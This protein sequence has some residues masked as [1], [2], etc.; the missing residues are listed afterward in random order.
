MPQRWVEQA[1]RLIPN[2]ILV[3]IP[4]AAH[5]VNFNAADALVAEVMKFVRLD[6]CQ[7]VD[8]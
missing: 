2:G 5:A 1:V 3:T 4:A 6:S 7:R 8:A